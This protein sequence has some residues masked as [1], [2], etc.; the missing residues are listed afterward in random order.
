MSAVRGREGRWVRPAIAHAHADEET[1]LRP[2]LTK[3]TLPVPKSVTP[4]PPF[5]PVRQHLAPP[6]PNPMLYPV[7][8]GGPRVRLG[9]L[10]I[11]LIR[12]FVCTMYSCRQ[13]PCTRSS[14]QTSNLRLS[15]FNLFPDCAVPCSYCALVTPHPVHAAPYSDHP[16]CTVFAPWPPTLSTNLSTFV[17][18]AIL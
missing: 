10:S 16:S 8:L 3:E 2:P 9:S 5:P 4:P 13:V 18:K 1:L 6:P 7:C 17:C 14:S 12:N 15:L 11:M